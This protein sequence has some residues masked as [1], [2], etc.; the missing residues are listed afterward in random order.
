[1]ARAGA[2]A[3]SLNSTVT[4]PPALVRRPGFGLSAVLVLALATVVSAF[5]ATMHP[6]LV[7]Y[8]GGAVCAGVL[9]WCV[10]RAPHVAAAALLVFVEL[11]AALK[12]YLSSAF[13]PAKDAAT[14]LVVVVVVAPV[15][16]SRAGRA[17][18]PDRW[19]LA[20][21]VALL[22]VYVLD[23]A[24]GHAAGWLP[25]VRLVG[26]S[27]G[28]FAV[29]WLARD[30][31]RSWRWLARALVGC[32]MVQ[33]AFGI[34]QQLLGADRLVT[35][36]GLAYGS[37]VRTTTSGQLRS[38]GT[39]DDPFNYG[40]ITTLALVV[41]A[42]TIR[43]AW[44]RYATVALLAVGVVVSVDRTMIVLLPVFVL[45]W[46][47][48]R[49][50][51]ALAALLI[52]GGIAAGALVLSLPSAP[53]PPQVVLADT[54]PGNFLLTLN[55]R[56]E[57]WS[58]VI[59]GPADVLFGRGV[60]VLGSGL[61]RSQQQGISEQARY[62]D[63]VAPPPAT[64]DDLTSLDNSYVALVADVG[65]LGLALLVLFGARVWAG[66]AAGLH[67]RTRP[68]LAGGAVLVVTLVDG[69]TRTSLTAFPFGFVA[70]LVLGAALA[71]VHAG[72]SAPSVPTLSAPTRTEGEVR[73]M[74]HE[75]VAH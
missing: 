64:N 54:A 65:L 21:L 12:F 29:G 2:R 72:P 57:T 49:G 48:V 7:L 60:G 27:F 18:V 28:L 20:A 68:A 1:L 74:H 66:L 22:T 75:A 17:R 45:L 36:L 32:G 69:L 63:G 15:L 26:E 9:A 67:T 5:A 56:T 42:V 34:V 33:S 19:L 62:V 31:A 51:A 47:A 46:L 25:A 37:Q 24:G 6:K 70:L 59:R 53:P 16:F 40:A 3:K 23:P 14:I 50:R 35:Q 39:F 55:G 30:P 38:L 13:G 10:W 4:L 41:A 43:R 44:L 71:A 8:G 52:A 61:A 11:Q 58:Q 73:S